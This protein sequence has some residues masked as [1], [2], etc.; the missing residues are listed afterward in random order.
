MMELQTDLERLPYTEPLL[1]EHGSLRDLT[2]KTG[3]TTKLSD[4]TK[5][6]GEKEKEKEKDDD[7]NTLKDVSDK[8]LNTKEALDKGLF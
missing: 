8:A 6:K 1:R 4:K 3:E 5:D 2:G 7:K